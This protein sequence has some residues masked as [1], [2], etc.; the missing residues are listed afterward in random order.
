M[1]VTGDI[2]AGCLTLQYALTFARRTVCHRGGLRVPR[3]TAKDCVNYT[4]R[5]CLVNVHL[6]TTKMKNGRVGPFP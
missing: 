5:F 2:S 1:P 3:H 4:R 6:H